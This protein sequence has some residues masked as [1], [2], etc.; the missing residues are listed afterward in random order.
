MGNQILL[1][2]SIYPPQVGGPAIFTSRFSRWLN[3]QRISNKVLTYTNNYSRR[4][5]NLIE[6]KLKPIRIYAFLKFIYIIITKTNRETLVLANGAFVETF[7]ACS[8]TRRNYVA[9][10]PGDP[11]WE[12]ARNK[13]WTNLSREDFQ[14][15]K[16]SFLQFFLRKLYNN[17]FRHAKWVICPSEELVHFVTGWGVA[18]DRIK[19]VYNCI[20]PL[21]FSNTNQVDKKYDL[22]TVS[23]LVNGKGLEELLACAGR[24]NLKLAVVGDGPLMKQLKAVAREL[25]TEIV[26]LGNVLNEE[27][28]KVLNQSGIFVLNSESEATSYALIEA[29]MCGLPVVAKKNSGSLTIVRHEIDG[30]IYSSNPNDGLTESIM[31]IASNPLLKREYGANGRKDAMLRFNEEK[32]FKLILNLLSS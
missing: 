1:I 7:L 8:L 14:V 16:L 27:V 28:P 3:S 24:L 10:I 4:K 29:K 31:K 20:N 23:R 6:V 25:E 26:F 32:N 9:K 21:D 2:T 13:N 12:Y 17:A 22:V 11:V 15:K 18:S 5:S 30:L 19:M